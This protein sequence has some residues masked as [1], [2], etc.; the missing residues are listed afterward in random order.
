MT[1]PRWSRATPYGRLYTPPNAPDYADVEE[2]ITQGLL[3]PSVTN[4]IGVADKPFL[5][6]WYA[7]MAAQNAVDTAYEHPGL[8]ESK[9]RKAVT[10]FSKAA[11]RHTSKAADLG[12]LVHS[13]CETLA[14]GQDP[15]AIPEHAAPYVDAWRAFRDDFEVTF[16]HVEATCFGEVPADPASAAVG[17]D[18]AGGGYGYAGTA[19]FIARIHGLRVVGD[20]KS[21]RSV[22]TEAALQASALAHC[23]TLITPTDEPTPAPD[24][25]AGIVIHLT[26]NGYRIHQAQIHGEPWDMFTHLRRVWWS[27][28]RNTTA[29]GP[30]F[31]T[32]PLDV[33]ADIRPENATQL[34]TP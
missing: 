7:K 1:T 22:H 16:E 11:E 33:P 25:D 21:G 14:L 18:P 31:L 8:I 26:P 12:D 4:V 9:P 13:I 2:A 10:H 3:V 15:G 5:R 32:G 29:R 27:H 17:A 30:L 23:H 20:L 24:I 6:G 34:V 28:V 19:D